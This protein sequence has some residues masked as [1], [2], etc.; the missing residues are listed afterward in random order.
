MKQEPPHL[1]WK[2]CPQLRLGTF[3]NCTFRANGWK[4]G[5]GRRPPHHRTTSSAMHSAT[6]VGPAPWTTPPIDVP[7]CG[8]PKIGYSSTCAT[9]GGDTDADLEKIT[10]RCRLKLISR[11]PA[12]LKIILPHARAGGRRRRRPLQRRKE[13]EAS[14]SGNLE[15]SPEPRHCLIALSIKRSENI[16]KTSG[17]QG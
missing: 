4:S 15:L 7:M 1:K 9:I 12:H 6:V 11:S 13:T 5:V 14:V 17:N 2:P 3:Y 10:G 16:A 8:N